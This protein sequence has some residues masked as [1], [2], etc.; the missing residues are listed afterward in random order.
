MK[1]TKNPLLFEKHDPVFP[2]EN[3]QSP[4][5][6]VAKHTH[7]RETR[8]LRRK[9]TAAEAIKGFNKEVE[10]YGFTKG[11]FSVIDI[12]EAVLE[13]TGPAHLTVSTWTAATTDVTSVIKFV[14]AHMCTT[15][16]WLVDYTFQQRSPE[17]AKRIRDVFGADAIRVG[18]N[19]AK[20]F[21]LQNDRWD[22]ICP[23]SMN[24]NFNPRFENFMLRNDPDM[25]Q[26][27]Q[28]IFDEIWT[29]Q[30]STLATQKAGVIERH[31]AKEM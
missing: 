16:R 29:N 21:M 14:Q 19:H 10:I 12:I 4:T 26:F 2:L 5:I 24:L 3:I 20:F 1:T 31:F 13:I 9:Q 22:I 23:T 7:K 17:L 25:C 6:R 27:H 18:K 15:S 30:K 28:S 11:Q 8:D